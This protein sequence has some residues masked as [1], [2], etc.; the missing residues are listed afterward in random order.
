MA[1]PRRGTQ[2]FSLSVATVPHPTHRRSSQ[3]RVRSSRPLT[4]PPRGYLHSYQRSRLQNRDREQSSA[5][6][7]GMRP[8]IKTKPLINDLLFPIILLRQGGPGYLIHHATLFSLLL[9]VISFIEQASAAVVARSGML[10]DLPIAIAPFL[11]LGIA[12][13]LRVVLFPVAVG[14]CALP[15]RILFLSGSLDLVELCEQTPRAIRRSCSTSWLIFLKLVRRAIS[16]GFIVGLFLLIG[17]GNRATKGVLLAT[18]LGSFAY[19]IMRIPLLCAPL[20]SIVGDYGRRYAVL[21]SATILH[22]SA[23]KMRWYVIG[24][25]T[26]WFLTHFAFRTILGD[27]AAHH[28]SILFNFNAIGWVWFGVTCLT[29]LVLHDAYLHERA[30]NSMQQEIKK[31]SCERDSSPMSVLPPFG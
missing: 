8:F 6:S 3:H 29:S 25:I 7:E 21:H 22:N 26:G 31:H 12:V 27:A 17:S 10:W 20:L 14:I 11:T 30:M 2:A 9:C 5:S 15:I 28:W 24:C 13:I 4:S 18:T 19:L 1:T 16:M 23:S